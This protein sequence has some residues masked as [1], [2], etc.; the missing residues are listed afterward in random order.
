VNPAPQCIFQIT[1]LFRT[2]PGV[3]QR[4]RQHS[5]ADGFLSIMHRACKFLS[6]VWRSRIGRATAAVYKS[7]LLV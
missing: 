6:E 5:D 7:S 2:N 4:E 1:S 3:R